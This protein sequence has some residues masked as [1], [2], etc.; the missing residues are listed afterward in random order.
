[1]NCI[2][3]ASLN[4]SIIIGLAAKF[5]IVRMKGRE[6]YTE[7]KIVIHAI[8][9]WIL[10]ENDQFIAFVFPLKRNRNIWTHAK[11]VSSFSKSE[12]VYWGER[13]TNV[14]RLDSSF[15][16]QR[17]CYLIVKWRKKSASHKPE[18]EIPGTSV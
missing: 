8:T 12:R 7:R 11:R 5:E 2:T 13:I 1:L 6:S 18:R 14:K 16:K 3:N 9:R 15:H 17:Y 10:I 4:P